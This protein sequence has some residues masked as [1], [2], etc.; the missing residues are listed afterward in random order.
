MCSCKLCIN[1]WAWYGVRRHHGG[2]QRHFASHLA[3]YPS[4]MSLHPLHVTTGSRKLHVLAKCTRA[5]A[6]LRMG[7]TSRSVRP[8]S[9]L[10]YEI[11]DILVMGARAARDWE[12][13]RIDTSGQVAKRLRIYPKRNEAGPSGR[14]VAQTLGCWHFCALRSNEHP[15]PECLVLTSTATDLPGR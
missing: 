8:Q 3:S 11:S 14:K 12:I 1:T 2:M 5:R 6:P 9:C 13:Q 10:Q 15:V 4:N 7:Q